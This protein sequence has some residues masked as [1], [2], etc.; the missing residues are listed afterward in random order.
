MHC[1][2]PAG[3][4]PGGVTTWQSAPAI[5]TKEVAGIFSKLQPRQDKRKSSLGYASG[6]TDFSSDI[7]H[8][9]TL[10]RQKAPVPRRERSNLRLHHR[11]RKDKAVDA[12]AQGEGH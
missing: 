8:H 3:G 4:I 1:P 9:D 6:M 5:T 11:H 2:S 10:Q 12:V 7:D